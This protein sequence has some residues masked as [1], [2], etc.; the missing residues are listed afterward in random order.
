MESSYKLYPDR[1]MK[2][3]T[4]LISQKKK[5]IIFLVILLFPYNSYGQKL[6]ESRQT[7]YYTYIYKITNKEA[8]T[9]YEKDI[10]KVEPSYFHTLVDSFPTDS[11]FCGILPK[12]HY[13]KTFAEKN[14]QKISITTVQDFDVFIFNNNTDLCIQVFDLKGNIINDATVSVRWKK[15]C[16]NKRTQ[17]YIDNKSNQK[18]LL[19][20]THYGFTGFYNLSR[21]YNNSC[22]KRG[23]RKVV[24]GT[25]IKYVWMPVNFIISLPID[26]VKS[27]V[28]GW[29]QGTI[30][31]TKNFFVKSFNKIACLFDD[32]YCNNYSNNKFRNKHT[33]YIVFSKPKYMPGDTVKFKAFVVT[34]K[35]KSIDKNVRVILQTDR[36]DIELTKLTPYCK[37]GYKYNFYLHDSLQLQL[38][39]NYSIR[40]ELN[41]RK[42]YINGSFKYEDYELSKNK[43]S[44]RV[45]K[46][47]HFRNNKITLYA[48]GTDENDLN[49]LDARIEVLLIP[50]SID[51]YFENHV[52]IPD[53]LLF[54][55]KKLNSTDETEVVLSN[56]TFPKA[57]FEYTINVRLFTSDNESVSEN[58]EISYFYESENFDITVK[59]DSIHFEYLKNGQVQPRQVSIN[60]EDNFG[61][62]T[63]VYKGLTPCN[64]ELNPY[65]SSYTIHTDSI[66]ETFEISKESS[67]LQCFSER[68]KDSI[69]IVVNNPRKIPFIYNIYK[70]NNEQSSGYSDSLV[71]HKKSATK[72]NYFVSIRYL[73]GGKV[74]E[75]NYRIPLIDN[76]LNISVTQPKIVYPGQKSR[77]ELLVTDTEGKP[78]EGVDLTA[79][80]LTKK[81]DYSAPE[82]PYMGKERKSK[83][84]I[85]NFNF[86]DFNLNVHP[87]LKLDYDSW[88]ILAGIDSIEYYK[89]IYPKNAIYRFEY[90]TRDAITQFA[91]FV[92][93]EGAILPIHVIYV[94]NKPVYFSWSTNTRPYSFSI[95][96]GYHQLKLR[97]TFREIVI[98]SMFF[99]K[100]KKLIFSLDLN[101]KNKKLN[102]SKVEPRLSESEKRYLYKYIVPYRDNFG[103]RYACIEQNGNIQLLNPESKYQR[104]NFAGPYVGNLTF[105]LIDKFSTTFYH[106]PFFEY[107]FLPALLKMR[108]ID[109]KEYPE[110]LYSYKANNTL[111]DAVVIKEKIEKQW[112]DYLDSKRYL[113]AR[114]RYPNSTS[115][116][117]G[118]LLINFKRSTEPIKDIPLN[119]LVFR[120]DNPEFLRVYPGNTSFF[121]ELQKG[122]HKLIFFYS[123]AKY[124]IEDS[125]YIQP[126]GLNYYEFK[127]P[128]SFQKDTFSVYVSNIIEE[129][130]F[131]P[132]PYYENEEKELKQIYNMYQQQFK[133]TGVGDVVEG[134]VYDEESGEP[135][136]G[137]NVSIKGT[138]YGTITNIDGYYS[139][140][141]PPGNS[142]LSFSFI[143]YVS[144]DKPLGYNDIV[145]VYLKA[146]IMKLEEVVVVGYGVQKK[147]D[148]TGSISVV[149]SSSLLGGIPGVSGNISE[150]LQGKVAGV[151]ISTNKCTP[152]SAVEISIRGTSTIEFDK[153]PLYIINGNVYTGDISELDPAIILN[154]QILKD[155]NATAIYGARG[156]NGVVIIE[157][158]SGA[159]KSTQNS[160]KGAEYDDT[161]LEAASNSS[162]I[163]NNFSDY[164]F[165]QP[166]LVTDKEGKAA[167]DVV[168][169]DD[170]TSWETFYLAMN[171]KRQSG[172]TEGLIKSYK[173]LMAQLALPR[174]LVQYDSSYA[175]GKVLNYTPDSVEVE[176]KLEVNG[177]EMLNKSRFCNNSLIDTLSVAATN[178]SLVVKYYL[179][180]KDGYFDGEQRDVTVFPKGLEATKG[181]FY[182]LDKDTTIQLQYD[183]TLGTVSL[184]ARADILDVIEDEISHL[185]EYK[186]SCNEQLASKLKALLAEKNIAYY[187]SENFKNDNEVEKLIRLLKKNQNENGLWGWWKNSKESLWIS[188]HVLEAL[189]HAELL[190]YKTSINN[191]QITELLIWEL[192][193]SRDFYEKIRILKILNLLRSQINYQ[194]YISDLERSEKIS[195]N[196]LL[197]IIELK[198]LCGIDYKLDTL[199]YYKKSTLFG[200]IFYSDENQ[201]TNLL[202][203][204]IQNTLLVYKIFKTD[205]IVDSQRLNKI[206]NYFLEN[207][208]NGYWRNTFESAQII[209]TILPDILKKQ[210]ELEKPELRLKGDI[211]KTISEFPFEIKI[212]PN[213]KMEVSKTGDFPVYLTTFQRYWDNAPNLKKDN[214]EISTSFDNKPINT[215]A[216]GQ[217]T[218]LITIVNVKKDAEYV[219]INIPIPGGCSYADKKNNLRNESHREYFKNETTIFCDYLPKGEYTFEIDLISRYS[220]TYT[221]NPAKIEL[222]YFPTFNANNEIK[223]IKIK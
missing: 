222:M 190:G 157:T 7:S 97:T 194:V 69:Y 120:Y 98:D 25:P 1:K 16:F 218:K 24:Y 99:E 188:L 5:T 31:R 11:G 131:K 176:A 72:Q 91:P 70:K 150:S 204:D 223:T 166:S 185:I 156:V 85:N 213:Q 162:S 81:F 36:K 18:G 169:P 29:P 63:S 71:I 135:L 201:E 106:E 65:Y 174:F 26:G 90:N 13:L 149:S 76:K 92:V 195:L 159:F 139:I 171:G 206:Q 215:L 114:Y 12:G 43:L 79:Y 168:F 96:S 66:S 146:D 57:N 140:K 75:E 102:I 109:S 186:Y 68:T 163:R 64:I 196:G 153:T 203:N 20:V 182:V 220:G 141:V 45:D 164:A 219:M 199:D 111:S 193:N 115:Q 212:S 187:K 33:G 19:K 180:T 47:E 39:R 42:E 67:L 73:W 133:Y 113:T 124:F 89:F 116:G 137:V 93:S 9:I 121:H 136:P 158:Q 104:N 49:L 83:S 151:V 144:E 110:Y 154:I 148:L 88:N 123:G 125:I 95:D 48:K 208:K 84:V 61:N 142:I 108:S 161:F 56:S 55:K 202:N 178:D 21:Q 40:L 10:W 130:L 134:Y 107:E 119:I 214:F 37:G 38:D 217:E 77:I 50:K 122:Y 8:R 27:V 54:L 189:T 138:T 211:N 152:G 216:A 127:Q 198:Q 210:S 51:N 192:E 177:K 103:E 143:G 35:G 86:K 197:N 175:I 44:L 128:S 3:K 132:N 62:K 200:N 170:V 60:S 2:N 80:S 32:Y 15:L 126:N 183:S 87:G 52:F 191:S 46:K 59:T 4:V 147:S 209:E 118:K 129:T 184:Y 101:S 160:L 74:K 155:A 53:T 179:K 22:I 41:E 58:V 30:Y 165:W 34:K 23:T 112:K 207:R 17:S 181:N 6:I 28:K 173:P 172:Q 205:S 78:L 82:L 167:F 100:G 94:D 145:N 117:A 105:Q 221:I 14:K